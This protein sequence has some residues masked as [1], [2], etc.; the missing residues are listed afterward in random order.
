MIDLLLSSVSLLSLCKPGSD[1]PMV[2]IP[3]EG[4]W[5]DARGYH[6]SNASFIAE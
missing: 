6:F 5:Q 3:R 1:P 2:Q 4:R